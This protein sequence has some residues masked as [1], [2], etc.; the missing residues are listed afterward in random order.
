MLTEGI[1]CRIRLNIKF[2][3]TFFSKPL[4]EIHPH[5]TDVGT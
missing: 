2:L 1:I 4:K 5:Y 3:A